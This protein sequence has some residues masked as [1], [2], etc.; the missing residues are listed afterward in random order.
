MNEKPAGDSCEVG[1]LNEKLGVV[2]SEAGLPNEK[3]GA[4]ESEA[5]LPNEK[6]EVGADGFAEDEPNVGVG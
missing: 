4:L 5:G 2:D 3:L 1:L 6:P